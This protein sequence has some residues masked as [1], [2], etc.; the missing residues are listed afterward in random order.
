MYLNERRTRAAQ[1]TALL[2]ERSELK[3]RCSCYGQFKIIH[4]RRGR[5]EEKACENWTMKFQTLLR[6]L[7]VF[8]QPLSIKKNGLFWDVTP[9]G[10][11]K[12]RR[13][14]GT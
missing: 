12:N 8:I 10:S 6:H 3:N 4:I 14:G 11:C 1:G 13:F 2:R 9:C 5:G 7:T